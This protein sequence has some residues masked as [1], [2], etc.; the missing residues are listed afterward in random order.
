MVSFVLERKV[1]SGN[2]KVESGKW[3]V[4]SGKW[5]VEIN[6]FL[7]MAIDKLDKLCSCQGKLLYD[8]YKIII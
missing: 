3:K 2:W 4:E 1:E 5:K 7:E 8:A 6:N